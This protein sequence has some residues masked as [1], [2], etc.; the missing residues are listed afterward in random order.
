M[1]EKVAPDQ[2]TASKEGIGASIEPI[3]VSS[4][5]ENMQQLV[6]SDEPMLPMETVGSSDGIK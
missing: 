2:S 5:R 3:H 4:G 1:I 6:A